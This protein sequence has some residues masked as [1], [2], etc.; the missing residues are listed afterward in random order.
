MR[1]SQTKAVFAA[2]AAALALAG[3]P[4]V[5]TEITVTATN[6]QVTISEH[7]RTAAAAVGTIL[8]LPVEIHTGADGSVD[9]LQLGSKL[10]IGPNST[11]AM[12]DAGPQGSIIDKIR[13][14][15]GYVLYN[16]KS[17]KI[18]PLSVETPY[19]VAVVKGTVFT[20]A[21]EEHA[22]QVA[23]MEGSLDISAPGVTRHVLLKPNESIRHADSEPDLAVQT[24]T[25][26][27]VQPGGGS[28]ANST[29]AWSDPTQSGQMAIVAKDLADA[30]VAVSTARQIEATKQSTSGSSNSA[31]SSGT[32]AGSS[33][34]GAAA[35]GTNSAGAT[36]GGSSASASSGT[37]SAGTGSS[38]TSGTSTSSSGNS[39]SGSSASSSTSTGGTTSSSSNTSPASSG[40]SSSSAGGSSSGGPVGCNGKSNGTGEGNCLGHK[41]PN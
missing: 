39:S 41:K 9:L 5:A 10:H 7:G 12:P 1:Q 34:A 21:V 36:S 14:T 40:S 15:A 25:S 23:L 33:G 28:A 4:A 38:S 31:S 20:I 17:R 3:T 24:S 11:I 32:S 26:R 37:T 8:T 6:G 35:S 19:L 16:I 18:Q 30:G 29:G 2:I 22:A 13:Q 27:V